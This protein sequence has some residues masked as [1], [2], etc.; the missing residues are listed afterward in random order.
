MDFIVIK[1]IDIINHMKTIKIAQQIHNKTNQIVK[2][3]QI[4]QLLHIDT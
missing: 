1:K 4:Y 3:M 2:N